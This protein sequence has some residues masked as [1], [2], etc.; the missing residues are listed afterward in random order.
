MHFEYSMAAKPLEWPLGIF[1]HVML[2]YPCLTRSEAE[3]SNAGMDLPWEVQTMSRMLVFWR[4]RER[5][6]NIRQHPT[7][8]LQCLVRQKFA[9]QN[10]P[11]NNIAWQSATYGLTLGIHCQRDRKCSP[12]DL[13][14]ETKRYRL[15]HWIPQRWL[16]AWTDNEIRLVNWMHVVQNIPEQHIFMPSAKLHPYRSTSWE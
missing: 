13:S 1:W 4:L 8:S 5:N 14:I 7:M 16:H 2:P 9:L 11:H 15:L 6:R 3:Q 12:R 10:Y